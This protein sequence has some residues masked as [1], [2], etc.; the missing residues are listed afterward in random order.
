VSPILKLTLL[1]IA[2]VGGWSDLRTRRIP[3]WLNLSGLIL[4][5][6]LNALFLQGHGLKLAATGLGLALL[7]YVPLYLI[8]AMGAG[9]VKFMAAI[10]AVVGPENWMA[11]FLT[12]AILGGIAS[13]CLVAARNRLHVT[14]ANLSTIAT[15]LL[16]GRMPFHKDPSLD[17][18]DG[19]ALG[20]PHGTIIAISAGLFL[21]FMY[22]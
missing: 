15:E 22:R 12:T 6:G 19:R 13:L 7:I 17:V 20:L 4:G 18:H 3:N 9:D 21:A 8:R 16:H 1:T 10:G 11:V 5:F 2:I 14:L